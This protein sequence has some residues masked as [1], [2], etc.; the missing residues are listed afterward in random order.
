MLFS[1]ED[2]SKKGKKKKIYFQHHLTF[3]SSNVLL[4]TMTQVK[5]ATATTLRPSIGVSL[6]CRCD[7][8]MS[9]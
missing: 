5:V 3:L 9:T 6:S 4:R 7:E 1:V 8:G 2:K